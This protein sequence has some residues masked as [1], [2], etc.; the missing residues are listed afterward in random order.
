MQWLVSTRPK[1]NSR[2]ILPKPNNRTTAA[3]S[4]SQRL[5]GLQL[6]SEPNP[7]DFAHLTLQDLEN[8]TVD[9]GKKNQGRTY[10]EIWNTDQE[11]VTFMA[12]RYSKSHNMSHRK[13]LRFVELM[14]QLHEE[15][16][17]PVVVQTGRGSTED[18]G[19]AASL[20]KAKASAKG[21]PKAKAGAALSSG[22]LEP[23]HFPLMDE[24]LQEEIEMYNSLTMVAPP[25]SQSPEFSAMQERMLNLENALTKVVN[26]LE[27][28]AMEQAQNHG[29][30]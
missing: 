8:E 30:Q 12:D 9:F 14:I 21:Q 15:Q 3:M 6:K 1:H 13:F 19:H 25:L 10:M 23:T 29:S 20:P 5:K 24:E 26:H 18:S 2:P 11:W 17:L 27:T 22:F 4:L 7:T 28:Q 16:Q